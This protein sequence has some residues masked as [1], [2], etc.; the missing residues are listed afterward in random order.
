MTPTD[1]PPHPGR[2]ALAPLVDERGVV[3]VCGTGGVG[4]T[5]TSAALALAAA[6]RGRRVV[7]VTIDPAR[8]LADA[9]GIGALGNTPRLVD[10]VGPGRL[11]AMM[12]DTKSTFDELVRR[13]ARDDTQAERILSNPFYRNISSGLSGTQD[14]MAVEKL[15]E[16]H[17]SGEW[18]LVVV[19]TPPSRDALA[20]LDAPRLL[21]RLLDNPVYKVLT[22]PNRGLLRAVNHAA[23]SLVRQLSR[24]VGAEIVD[25]AVAFFQAFEGMEDGFRARAEAT[26]RLLGDTRTAFVLVASPRPDVTAE[27]R[28]FARRLNEAG[29]E[30]AALVVNRLLPPVTSDPAT[31]HRVADLLAP[32]TLAAT[33]AALAEH[34]GAVAVERERVAELATWAPAAPLIG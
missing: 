15:N 9:L 26:L 6:R 18:D 8:R 17:T 34:A 31:A 14:Y 21:T 33:A 3:V 13:H 2:P 25:E 22:A 11:G 19:D 28:W 16:L 30:V 1:P 29:I 5:T 7:V 20:F 27:S 4:K 23:Q 24:V 32:S 10:G 12:L